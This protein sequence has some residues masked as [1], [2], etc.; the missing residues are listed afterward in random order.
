MTVY[1]LYESTMNNYLSIQ[2]VF[3]KENYFDLN[4]HKFYIYCYLDP[5]K[6]LNKELLIKD[7]QFGINEKI[8]FGY[9]PIYIG[10]ASTSHGY[11]HNQ[12]IA[13]FLKGIDSEEPQHDEYLTHY[14]LIKMQ[15]F[16]EIG[17]N[18]LNNNNPNLPS[19][20]E[21]YQKYW[22][23]ILKTFDTPQSLLINE[24]VFI[25]EIGTIKNNNGPLTNGQIG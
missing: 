12:H 15:K 7:A 18:M 2:K 16:K 13:E 11:R 22:I 19:S 1:E 8:Q 25:R 9:E 6:P 17:Q 20:W 4:K 5:F 14:N 3:P 21:E 23:I 24:K 10:K